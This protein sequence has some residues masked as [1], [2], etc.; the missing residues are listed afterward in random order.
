MQPDPDYAEPAQVFIHE[1][2]RRPS[3]RDYEDR[4]SLKRPV[5]F[6]RLESDADI[7]G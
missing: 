4:A 1:H 3:W 7:G 2:V 6:T 5:W